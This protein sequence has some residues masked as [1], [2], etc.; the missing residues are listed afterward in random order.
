MSFDSESNYQDYFQL[1]EL[2]TE[3]KMTLP[4]DGVLITAK[5]ASLLGVQAGDSVTLVDT[6]NDPYEFFVKGAWTQG[7]SVLQ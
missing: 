7:T 4:E 5:L 6:N 1:Q 2:D 3:N